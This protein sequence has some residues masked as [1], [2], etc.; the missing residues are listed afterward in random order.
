MHVQNI[1]HEDFVNY[2]KPS[3]FIGVAYCSGKCGEACQNKDLMDNE[4]IEI[5][6]DA[7]IN[8]YVNNPLTKAIVFGGLEPF[9]QWTEL[10][11]FL[12]K[13]RDDWKCDDD[14]V[15]YTGYNMNEVIDKI[16]YLRMTSSNI[17]I[18]LGRY[19]PDLPPK[20]DNNLG[21]TLASNNQHSIV[22]NREVT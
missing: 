8:A 3:M 21:V 10:K 11:Q 12:W 19:K 18:K 20:F 22:I 5:S 9:D 4:P 7:I 17:I 15:I 14:V 2:K 6:D 1:I 16:V 13:L